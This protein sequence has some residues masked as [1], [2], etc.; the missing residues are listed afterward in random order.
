MGIVVIDQIVEAQ[1][2]PT[3]SVVSESDIGSA[4]SDSFLLDVTNGHIGITNLTTRS[5][6]V[7]TSEAFWTAAGVTGTPGAFEMRAIFEPTYQRWV[8]SGDEHITGANRR[9]LAVSESSNPTG[10][11]HA[12]EL[13]PDGVIL[14]TQLAV[15]KNGVYLT[16][17]RAAGGSV[18]VTYPAADLFTNAPTA[19]HAQT[20]AIPEDHAVPTTDIDDTKAPT[21][22]AF[23]VARQGDRTIQLYN[24]TWS[25]AVAALSAPRGIDLG[26]DVVPPPDTA[27]QPDPGAPIA[28]GG[29]ALRTAQ[30]LHDHLYTVA[31]TTFAGHSA[32]VWLEL[33]TTVGTVFTEEQLAIPDGDV[34]APTIGVGVFGEVGLAVTATSVTQAPFVTVAGRDSVSGGS[35]L[36]SLATANTGQAPFTCSTGGFGRTSSLSYDPISEKFWVDSPYSVSSSDCLFGSL[37][38]QFDPESGFL[39]DDFFPPVTGGEDPEN[40]QSDRAFGCVCRSASAPDVGGLALVAA[41]LLV[42]RRRQ[43]RR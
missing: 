4:A 5:H 1:R 12:L 13:G 9:Y 8:I 21:D 10:A 32:A 22:P 2:G 23:V 20:F 15:D 28:V 27:A 18:L 42:R 38:V 3:D 16:G 6:T 40:T 19:A 37:W 26:V 36:S 25:G 41:A 31:L 34:L 24:V 29:N 30:S 43:P 17:Q 35:L 39:G 33:E 7:Q 11:W 14:D